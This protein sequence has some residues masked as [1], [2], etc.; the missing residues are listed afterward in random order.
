MAG[1]EAD[2]SIQQPVAHDHDTFLA[3]AKQRPGFEAV[4]EGLALE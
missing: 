3:K 1:P 4:Y 2:L